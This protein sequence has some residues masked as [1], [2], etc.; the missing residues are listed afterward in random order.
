V[1]ASNPPALPFELPQVSA[2]LA[3]VTPR[4]CEVGR[5]AAEAVARELAAL[6]G[7]EVE[8][9]GAPLPTPPTSAAWSAR[10]PLE[11]A[12][13]PGLAVLD[14]EPALAASVLDRLAGGSA[15]LRPRLEAT[16]LER[17]A[18]ELGAL[19]ALQGIAALPEVDGALAPRLLRSGAP[20]PGGLAI[21]LRVR[22]GAASGR[23]RLALPR[24]ALLRLGAG[25]PPCTDSPL[26]IEL[27]VREGSAAL[28]A[29]ELAA[30]ERGDVLLLGPGDGRLAARLPGGVRFVG[31]A[32]EDHLHVEEIEMTPAP[33][34]YPLVVEVELARVPTTLGEVARLVPGSLL[35]LALDRR[36]TVALKVGDR[37]IARGQLV[38]V[39]GAIG[40]RIEAVG[41]VA[42]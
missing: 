14:V 10:L 37:T 30:L 22:I 18:L 16:P 11:L 31:R 13:L 41:G 29:A 28:G 6:L 19:A 36:G 4:L 9:Q 7:A 24:E 27:S 5:R 2:A 35:P 21:A 12:A 8:I 40:V 38:D 20:A 42:P 26:A 17:A 33:A 15:P 34:D 32:R 25:H 1:T 23:C 39:E 3:L